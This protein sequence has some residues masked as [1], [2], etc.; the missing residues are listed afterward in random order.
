MK[1]LDRAM[2]SGNQ[3][4]LLL[5]EPCNRITGGFVSWP[6][7]RINVCPKAVST[8]RCLKGK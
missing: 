8:Y 1:S 2:I 7:D 5:Q 4:A 3:N 6:A